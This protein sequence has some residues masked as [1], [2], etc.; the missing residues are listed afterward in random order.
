[1]SAMRSA[2][3]G[4]PAAE[5]MHAH[6]GSIQASIADVAATLQELFGQRLVAVMVGADHPKTVGRWVR[7]EHRPQ[8]EYEQALRDG[9]QVAMLLLQAEDRDTVR[10]WFVGMNPYLDD[11]APTLVLRER[12]TDVMRAARAYLAGGA[13]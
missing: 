12:P 9:Y 3:H 10:A 4:S 1:M 13:S 6:Q 8:P 11:R 5:A 7:G 2:I